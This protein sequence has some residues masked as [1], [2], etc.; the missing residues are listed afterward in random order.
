MKKT[1]KKFLKLKLR[2][3][4]ERTETIKSVIDNF[5]P[6]EEEKELHGVCIKCYRKVESCMRVKKE[7]LKLNLYLSGKG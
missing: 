1:V 3:N 5:R 6:T 7:H 2:L 4:A